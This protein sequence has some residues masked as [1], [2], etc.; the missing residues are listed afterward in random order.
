[1]KDRYSR[2]TLFYY[3]GQKGQEKLSKSRVALIGCGGLGSI[4][5]NSLVRAGVGF[6]RIV[7][8]DRLEASNLQRQILYDEKDLE[9]M[10]PK[11]K[12]AGEK[13]KAVNSEVT[14]EALA[15]EANEK[16]IMEIVRDVDLVM[17]G[18]D[19]LKTRFLIN[20]A[21]VQNKIPWIY[22]SVAGS[23]GMV[24]NIIPGKTPCL[25]CIFDDADLDKLAETSSNVGILNTAVSVIASI[26]STEAIKL[27]T[28]N[29]EYLLKGLAVIDIWDF[30]AE[31]IEIKREASFNCPVCGNKF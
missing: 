29:N 18:T 22:A 26:Q 3:I 6:I 28:G 8:K 24:F 12:I 7:D 9:S 13:L 5:A 23:Y 31:I 11:A 20:K 19:N 30:S 4:I 1:M 27:L 16:N 14:I 2:Q 17:D 10:L 25:R 21:C 15:E